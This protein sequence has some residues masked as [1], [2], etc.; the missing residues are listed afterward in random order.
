[1]LP[2]RVFYPCHMA[3]HIPFIKSYFPKEIIDTIEFLKDGFAV[4][5]NRISLFEEGK[6]VLKN[7]LL[8]KSFPGSHLKFGIPLTEPYDT[9]PIQYKDDENYTY[10]Y[11][12]DIYVYMQH[13]GYY[14]FFG[15]PENDFISSCVAYFLKTHE[16]KYNGNC[17]LT[18]FDHVEWEEIQA[19][20]HKFVKEEMEKGIERVKE[21]PTTIPDVFETVKGILPPCPRD[22][23]Y[24]DIAVL[25]HKFDDKFPLK[26]NEETYGNL[27]HWLE[28]VIKKH[29]EIIEQYDCWF[30]PDSE[31]THFDAKLVR[32]F[33]NEERDFVMAYETL[34]R[35]DNQ[36]AHDGLKKGIESSSTHKTIRYEEM[37]KKYGGQD[38]FKFVI[39]SI[40]RADRAPI[41]IPT[42][43]G[44]YCYFASDV[45][46]LVLQDLITMTGLFQHV[47]ADNW[48]LVHKI[49][50]DFGK[51]LFI[52]NESVPFF[53][54]TLKVDHLRQT[55]P[56]YLLNVFGPELQK[57]KGL[58]D[59]PVFEP[60][61]CEEIIKYQ[62]L[63]KAMPDLSDY[64]LPKLELVFETE[65]CA[66]QSMEIVQLNA[67]LSKYL[68]KPAYFVHTQ[69]VCKGVPMTCRICVRK[70]HMQKAAVD[71]REKF[72]S[73]VLEHKK[74]KEEAERAAAEQAEKAEQ[75]GQAALENPNQPGSSDPPKPKAKPWKK[76][77]KNKKQGPNQGKKK[78]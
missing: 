39:C 46:I 4:N 31:K 76:D 23:E 64:N 68:E 8:F 29:A 37:I 15:V 32:V 58:Q 20:F 45:V 26:G 22:P 49:F 44:K 57:I 63:E 7:L 16:M 17:E 53:I 5:D 41:P 48:N 30:L 62:G 40:P 14:D 50:D 66:Y 2:R 77:K 78:K 19:K 75:A 38:L 35:H 36:S 67:L 34:L 10:M 54:D 42:V 11:K 27:L 56:S 6:G 28:I 74:V 18:E 12:N 65:A 72:A 52:M 47:H 55:L 60:C 21:A 13:L 1:M 71:L 43:N 61:T 33:E 73:I 3:S 9:S 25:V 51:D 70:E 59:K 24:S 69:G